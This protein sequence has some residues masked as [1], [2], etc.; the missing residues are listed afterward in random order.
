MIDTNVVVSALL[1]S[2]SIPGV[3]LKEA[4]NGCITPLLHHDILE[5]YEEVLQRKKFRFD[6][7]RIQT[8]LD[9][10]TSRGIFVSQEN[11]DT[12]DVPDPDDAIFYEVAI[13]AGKTEPSYLTT[14]NIRHFPLNPF[15]VSPK[16]MLEIILNGKDF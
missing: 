12:K 2:D 8:V 4:L 1:K 11:I 7:D 16:E 6:H 15:V 14:G 10:L 5:E 13:E 9:R 3:I